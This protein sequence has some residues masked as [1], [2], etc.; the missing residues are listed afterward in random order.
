MPVEK[1]RCPRGKC[2][3]LIDSRLF[4][5]ARD[6]FDLSKS[7]RTLIGATA[8]MSPLALP[9]RRAIEHALEEW[10]EIDG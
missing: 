10:K 8:Q 4:C 6:W 3:L 7:A 5:C 9:R 1:H 2:N